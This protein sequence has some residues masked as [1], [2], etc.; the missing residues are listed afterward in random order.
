MQTSVLFI[1]RILKTFNLDLV[2]STKFTGTQTQNNSLTEQST[3][4]RVIQFLIQENIYDLVLS[5]A[6]TYM[7][8]CQAVDN[9]SVDTRVAPSSPFTHKDR[10]DA[11]MNLIEFLIVNS[12]SSNLDFN[13]LSMLYSTFVAQAVTSYENE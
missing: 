11:T 7:K 1:R 8:S 2:S 9:F 12:K 4:E 6:E 13:Q 10:I 5:N 3:R